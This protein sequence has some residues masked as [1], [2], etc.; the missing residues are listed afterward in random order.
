MFKNIEI[1]GFDYGVFISGGGVN[2]LVFDNITV[3]DQNICGFRTNLQVVSVHKL[4]SN[5][6]VP[7]VWSSHD[8]G[9][10]TLVDASLTGGSSSNP[11]IIHE[12][13]V[14]FLR[15]ITSS[16]YKQILENKIGASI[17]GNTITEYA[18]PK[19]HTV[20]PSPSKTLDLAIEETPS[21]VWDAPSA[22]VNVEDYGATANG[23]PGSGD[24]TQ[25][26]QDAIDAGQP[27]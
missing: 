16:G 5:N 10:L 15:D 20:H 22:W 14:L 11:A 1:E 8:Q 26:F 27:R 13:G 21:V 24:D 19:I 7:A 12:H 25:A 17:G 23:E 9:S 3:S 4:I 2:S 6:S 18:F